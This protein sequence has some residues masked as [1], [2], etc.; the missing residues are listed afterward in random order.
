MSKVPKERGIPMTIIPSK[1]NTTM[2]LTR[3]QK[4]DAVNKCETL[5]ELAAVI[6]SFADEDGK[7]Q[8]RTRKFNANEM[9]YAAKHFYKYSPNVLTREFGIRQQA[10]YIVY[11]TE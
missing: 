7:I 8:G 2:D 10:I 4:Y 11:Y 6:R 9:A 3:E 5:N 1:P